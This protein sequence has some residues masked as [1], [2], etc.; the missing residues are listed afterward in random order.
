MSLA[1]GADVGLAQLLD[2]L[3]EHGETT[4]PEGTVP[5]AIEKP[6]GPLFAALRRI[7]AQ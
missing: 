2:L 1:A 3:A 6:R 5:V 7:A 4:G